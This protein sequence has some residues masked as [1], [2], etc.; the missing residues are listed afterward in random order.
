MFYCEK[1]SYCEEL[2]C[3][4]CRYCY[5][6]YYLYTIATE[7]ALHL[8]TSFASLTSLQARWAAITLWSYLQLLLKVCDICFVFFYI[9][10]SS[11]N[12]ATSYWH[13]HHCCQHHHQY[14]IFL[15]SLLCLSLIR[16][17]L[18]GPYVFCAKGCEQKFADPARSPDPRA[19]R[20][21]SDKNYSCVI[22]CTSI[23]LY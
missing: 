5:H 18:R 6:S 20:A 14:S 9:S 13:P 4:Y 17:C 21:P 1:V 3:R 11:R 10:S 12:N 23:V 22:V 8:A 16:L 7:R 19:R 2:S 15:I